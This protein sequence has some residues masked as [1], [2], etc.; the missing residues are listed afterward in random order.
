M[1]DTTRWLQVE[2]LPSV[3]RA[4]EG[5]VQKVEKKIDN[6]ETRAAKRAQQEL[7]AAARYA[8]RKCS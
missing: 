1:P 3:T 5:A 2:A 7:Y 8:H 4:V 6:E